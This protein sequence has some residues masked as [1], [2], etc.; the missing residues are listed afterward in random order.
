MYDLSNNNDCIVIATQADNLAYN[1]FYG[2]HL[3]GNIVFRCL[4]ICTGC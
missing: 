2:K 4:L 3:H 1:Y